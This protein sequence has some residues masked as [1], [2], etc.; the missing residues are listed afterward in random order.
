MDHVAVWIEDRDMARKK[1]T[2]EQLDYWLGVYYDMD[3]AEVLADIAQLADPG[4]KKDVE[5]L[6]R[7]LE[8]AQFGERPPATDRVPR[9][10]AGRLSEQWPFGNNNLDNG[11]LR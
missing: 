11:L 4:R 5:E 1:L 10:L 2:E 7:M 6:N 8:L 3:G 9:T